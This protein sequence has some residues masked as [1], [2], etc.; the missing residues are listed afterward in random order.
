MFLPDFVTQKLAACE[1]NQ[2]CGTFVVRHV[3]EEEKTGNVGY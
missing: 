1:L 2:G 3:A